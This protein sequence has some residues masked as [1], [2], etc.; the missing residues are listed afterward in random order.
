MPK[1]MVNPRFPAPSHQGEM[2]ECLGVSIQKVETGKKA[3]LIFYHASFWDNTGNLGSSD[4]YGQVLYDQISKS[5][6]EPINAAPQLD[7]E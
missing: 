7:Y 5:A 2:V 1:R 3:I 6:F 4:D